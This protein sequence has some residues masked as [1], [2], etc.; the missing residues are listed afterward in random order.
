MDDE[1]YSRLLGA[2]TVLEEAIIEIGKHLPALDSAA[3]VRRMDALASGQA[4][5]PY[6]LSMQET[7]QRIARRVG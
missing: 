2:G 4:D 5:S 3:L 7:A 1:E 6:R